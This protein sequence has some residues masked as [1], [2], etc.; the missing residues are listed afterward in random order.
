M[1]VRD[2]MSKDLV[3]VSPSTPVPEA[4]RMM[5][6]RRIR[7][8]P[9]V[10]DGRLVGIVTLLDLFRVSPSPATSLSIWELNYLI[11][12]LPVEEAMTRKVITVSPDATLEEAA[13]LMR[14][15]RV[16]GLPVVEDGRPVGIITETDI[17]DAFLDLMGL[18]Q[19]GLRVT[20][21]LPDRVGML[22]SVTAICRDHG[23]NIVSVASFPPH[24]GEARIIMRLS[25]EQASKAVEAIRDAGYRVA[26]VR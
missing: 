10:Q 25:G 18:R 2:R 26:D 13:L 7:R 6:Q 1:L 9:V 3:T 11:A 4:L 19:P 14:H 5:E 22:A 15:H 20:L 8:L 16:G 21:V 12:R 17:F 24:E 23:V